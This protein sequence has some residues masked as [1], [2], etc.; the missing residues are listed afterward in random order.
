M[1]AFYLKVNVSTKD[2]SV[3]AEVYSAVD[4]VVHEQNH[5]YVASDG[6]SQKLST[7][8]FAFNLNPKAGSQGSVI[9]DSNPTRNVNAVKYDW[10]SNSTRGSF[11]SNE[12][13]WKLKDAASEIGSN[14]QVIVH[15]YLLSSF[16]SHGCLVGV[17]EK[18]STLYSRSNLFFFSLNKN[19]NQMYELLYFYR[20]IQRMQMKY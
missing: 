16:F 17:T 4:A 12:N 13:S 15:L 11:I 6:I 3:N 18:Y 2:L 14:S 9:S 5:L 19:N 10:N 8:D 7:F 1:T 20:K